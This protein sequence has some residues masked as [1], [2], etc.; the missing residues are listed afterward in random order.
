MGVGGGAQRPPGQPADRL[1]LILHCPVNLWQLAL[2]L[3]ET[4]GPESQQADPVRDTLVL[5]GKTAI[6]AGWLA[7]CYV[8]KNIILRKLYIIISEYI[9]MTC[10]FKLSSFAVMKV[11]FHTRG[12]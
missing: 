4:T 7:F 12:V 10:I 2:T 3:L 8:L 9:I 11:D 1:G 6:L 5:K